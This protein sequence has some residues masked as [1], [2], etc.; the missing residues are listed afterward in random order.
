MQFVKFLSIVSFTLLPCVALA[1]PFAQVSG[2]ALSNHDQNVVH[3]NVM[4]DVTYSTNYD[5]GW[6]DT[7]SNHP[8]IEGRAI[9]AA[10]SDL[11]TGEM[12]LFGKAEGGAYAMANGHTAFNDMVTFDFTGYVDFSFDVEGTVTNFHDPTASTSSTMYV[13]AQLGSTRIGSGGITN[14]DDVLGTTY[15]GQ[16]YV[17]AGTA[18]T[19]HAY[20]NF[21]VWANEELDASHTAAF[22]FSLPTDGNFTSESGIFLSGA[23][24]PDPVPEPATMLL[25]GT[26]LVGLIGSRF[27]K[28]KK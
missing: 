15:E 2:Q 7:Y 26:G 27:R 6:V 23:S 11:A 17:T 22:R 8:N 21:V 4:D 24:I 12:K 13:I 18:Y 9:S 3:Y 16:T 28:K 10:S 14:A 5:T 1:L 19:V 20:M 25:F